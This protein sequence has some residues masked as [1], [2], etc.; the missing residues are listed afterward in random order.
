MLNGLQYLAVFIVS[1]ILNIIIYL[2]GLRQSYGSF[3]IIPFDFSTL[4]PFYRH[5]SLIGPSWLDLPTLKSTIY[6]SIFIGI[7]CLTILLISDLLIKLYYRYN[8]NF[9]NN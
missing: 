5:F 8:N 7:F 1:F 9:D 2:I 3:E 4:L 6:S